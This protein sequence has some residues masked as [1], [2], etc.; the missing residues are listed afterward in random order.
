[1]QPDTFDITPS[2]RVLRMLGQIDFAAWQCLAELIDNSMDAFLEGQRGEKPLTLDPRIAIEL[3]S[4]A[5]L[6]AGTGML[7][8]RDNGPGMTEDQLN[9]AVKAGY[10]R[11]DPVEKLGLFGMGFNISTA[12]LGK[13]TEVWTT[14]ADAGDW[15]GVE[16]DFELL[17]QADS[18]AAPRL[19]RSK[20]DEE[21]QQGL[22]G[23]IVRV[24]KL[25]PARVRPLIWGAGKA[26]TRRRL[27]KIYS[28]VIDQIGVSISYDGEGIRPLRH[29][30]WNRERSVSN[31]DF[32]N[33]PALMDVDETIDSRRFCD[34][35]W[36]WLESMDTMC[37]ACGNSENVRERTRR[38]K[39]WIGVQRYF[40]KDHF[41]IDLIRN[42]RV[43]EELNKSLF[44]WVDPETNQSEL[45]YPVDTTHWGGRIV[46]ELEIDFVRV[47]HQK[48]SFDKLDPQWREVVERVR[49]TSPFRP[50]I[51]Q[52]RGYPANTSP[53]GR[54][55]AG[56]RKGGDAGFPDLVPAYEDGRGRNDS[57]I[58]EWVRHF[59]D[60]DPDYRTDEKWYALVLLAEQVKRGAS[61]G[62]QEAAGDLPIL[63]GDAS[64]EDKTEPLGSETT[65]DSTTAKP[66]S[67]QHNLFESDTELSRTYRLEQLPGAPSTVVNAKRV[68]HGLN[69][70]P[71]L[72]DTPASGGVEFQYDPGHPFFEESLETPLD[73]L[74][75]D[76]AH[77]FLLLSGQHQRDYPL[78]TIERGIRENY[79]PETLTSVAEAA[80]EAKAILDD[81]RQF[82]DENLHR[83][84]P[85]SGD[86]VDEHTLGLIRKGVLESALG[87]EQ[88]VQQSI[89]DGAFVRYVGTDFL[90]SAPSLWP[91][92]ILDGSFVGVPYED[93]SDSH[94][95]DSV[96]MVCDA[97]RDAAWI[98]SDSG[99][100][101]FSKDQRW[102]LRLPGH[103][104]LFACWRVGEDESRC[105]V[106]LAMSVSPMAPG[107]PRNARWSAC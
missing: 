40:D 38:I 77:R 52:R 84:A 19:Q 43:I 49:G 57:V 83:A 54:L 56:Y 107:K 18:F 104:H 95:S 85:I 16:I 34:V 101:A 97:L 51:A 103:Y 98:V 13:R 1:M 91:Q 36:V 12:R 30:V 81:L 41:G 94:R 14:T 33:I 90:I 70:K 35:C 102:R 100:G 64:P 48:D 7:T 32:G 55:F 65:E 69:G 78:A 96:A 106:S 24:S 99:G 82:L 86:S 45:E 60:G 93:V 21:L 5:S 39:G 47:S 58:L 22:H 25:D 92:L 37:P 53:L 88:D 28:R 87:G 66:E 68:L 9:K 73:C 6:D 11:N 67:I 20:S 23:T 15:I 44:N 46:G 42:G 79:F 80:E 89:R 29:C 62:S 59:H 27:G 105:L 72:F 8:V 74:V 2:T 76:L 17:E 3:P 4:A 26:A 10:S 31:R 71:I 63:N 75:S 61:S 50:Q